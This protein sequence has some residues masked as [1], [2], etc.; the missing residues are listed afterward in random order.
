MQRQR[1]EYMD[2]LIIDE[3]KEEKSGKGIDKGIAKGKEKGK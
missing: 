1:K 2:S 3:E